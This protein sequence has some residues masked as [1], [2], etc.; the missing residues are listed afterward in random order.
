[1]FNGSFLRLTGGLALSC[2][3]SVL[4]AWD[5]TGHRIVNEAALASLPADFPAFVRAPASAERI[6]F[7]AGEPDRWR[8][9]NDLPIKHVN[10]MDH[11]LDLEELADAGLEVGALPS[12][13]YDFVM[14]FAAGRAAHLEKF[15]AFDPAK[16]VEHSRI[17]PG[18]APW[19]VAE[20]YG[21]LKSAFSY[22]KALEENGTPEEVANAQA[23]ILYVMGVMGHYVGDLAQPLHVTVHHHGWVGPNPNGYTTAGDI[24]QWIDGG[25]IAGAGITPAEV[26]AG[27]VPVQPI[28]VAPRADQRDPL[29]VAVVDYL[30]AQHA[31]VEPLYALEKAGHFKI[32]GKG[33]PA[34]GRAFIVGQLHRGGEMLG[35]VWLTAW[36]NAGPDVY[37]RG[38]LIKRQAAAAAKAAAPAKP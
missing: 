37:L 30:V 34:P 1:M 10:G 19:A 16:D 5:Y 2:A 23:N 6:A 14:A 24:H 12:M 22:L 3:A 17:W 35:A 9:V 18:F 26:L 21:K 29:F 7:L 13:R 25:F 36:R 20:Q 33:D 38:Q 28:S 4:H 11:Y 27:A 8:N 15:P 31:Q 32:D